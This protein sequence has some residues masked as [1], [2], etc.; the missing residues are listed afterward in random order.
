[1]LLL[2]FFIIQWYKR[3]AAYLQHSWKTPQHDECTEV[4]R[5]VFAI[6]KADDNYERFVFITGITKFTQISLFSVLNNLTNIS[7]DA[8]DAAQ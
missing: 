3:G 4:Y 7:F 6:L 8:P 2:L 1:M 5:E